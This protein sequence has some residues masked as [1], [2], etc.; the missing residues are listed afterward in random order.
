MHDSPRETWHTNGNTRHC[1][2]VRECIMRSNRPDQSPII[3]EEVCT[4]G[5]VMH[6]NVD[7]L[8]A[9]IIRG[10]KN[11]W[12]NLNHSVNLV[13]QPL[14]HVLCPRRLPNECILLCR[15]FG[16]LPS[17]ILTSYILYKSIC[18]ET[19]FTHAADLYITY[20]MDKPAYVYNTYKTRAL[21]YHRIIMP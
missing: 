3:Y 8:W 13:L 5:S 9:V 20:C 16:L 15:T 1:D 2:P 6:V 12:I 14:I 21:Y 10:V 7:V 18:P 19:N 11:P 17:R 4:D